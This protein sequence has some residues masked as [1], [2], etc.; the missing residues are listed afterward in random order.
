MRYNKTI[1]LICISYSFLLTLLFPCSGHS[2]QTFKYCD[3][4]FSQ[5]SISETDIL[6][7][8]SAIH[9]LNYFRSQEPI[10]LYQQA[11]NLAIQNHFVRLSAKME[12]EI[13]QIYWD[14][15]NLDSAQYYADHAA[16]IFQEVGD[17]LMYARTANLRR[18]IYTRKSEFSKAYD[19]CFEALEIFENYG[20]KT[21][22]A[23]TNRDVGSIML[24]E[25]K[26]ADA[27][28]YCL[29]GVEHL[30]LEKEWLELSFS[31]QRIAIV[32]RELGFYQ[33]AQEYVQKSMD[34]CR[35]LTDF[36]CHSGL[37]DKYWTRGYIYEAMEEFDSAIVYYDSAKFYAQLVGYY[38]IDMWIHN[39]I[40]GVFLKQK[41]YKEALRQFKKSRNFM[42]DQRITISPYNFFLPIYTNLAETY[43]GLGQYQQAY[44]YMYDYSI[45]KDSIFKIEADRQIAE[46][47]TKYE[48]SQKESTIQKL[49]A[50]KMA[51]RKVLLLGMVLLASL[52]VV[53]I[54][55]WRNNRY[56]WKV[57]QTLESQKH[58][59]E[60]KN[61]QNE[62][63]M[64]EI[65]H[66]VKN[67]LQTI[68]S[69]L[70]LQSK[71]LKDDSVKQAILASQNRVNTM[72]LIH[73]KLYQGK[74]LEK[75]EMKDYLQNL[76]KEIQKTTGKEKQR[77]DFIFDMNPM[78]LNIDIAIPIGLIVNELITNSLKHA[79]PNG[80][81][82]SITISLKNDPSSQK[83]N[84][85]Y[86]DNGIGKNGNKMETNYSFGTQLIS[87][88]C[89]QL[90]GTHREDQ[91]ERGYLT[92]ISFSLN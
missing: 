60:T 32:Y 14:L 20:D 11:K 26:Y 23:I 72:A 50:D 42:E 31:Y 13:A 12:M 46:I 29:S 75:I 59:I 90:K 83:V 86:W 56:R 19:I 57:N 64:K 58:L 8:D 92:R 70:Y 34:A 67:N 80:G 54:L 7:L 87:L 76:G 35:M 84:L 63:L 40:G 36:R 69:L 38:T 25:K 49:Q 41:K 47:R 62:L 16:W 24:Q 85:I 77:I 74:N 68:S 28:K 39:S 10:L 82:G 55:L 45:A 5:K 52:F 48:T 2:Q 71:N 89:T 91:V 30:E 37:A 51:Q 43:A 18:N 66:R 61:A 79:F 17:E 53:A 65:H 22:I 4:L 88:L 3:S 1:W 78:E 73:Q 6:R 27:L 15:L 81:A 44:K 9:T 21:G 33:K